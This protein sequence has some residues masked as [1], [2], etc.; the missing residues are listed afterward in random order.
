M[1]VHG[2]KA[3]IRKFRYIEKS[4]TLRV[5]GKRDENYSKW[6]WKQRFRRRTTVVAVIG[7]LKSDFRMA[8]N[9]LKGEIGDKMN[10][11][12][13]CSAFNFKKLMRELAFCLRNIITVLNYF[14]PPKTELQRI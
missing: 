6:Q 8:R 13:A 7:H 1:K 10:L 9:Y 2:R 14:F 12:L 3:G 5:H 4:E 11:L